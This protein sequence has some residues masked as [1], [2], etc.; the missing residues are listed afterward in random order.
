MGIDEENAE[1]SSGAF[2]CLPSGSHDTSLRGGW[3]GRS[4]RRK[5]VN[6]V[7]GTLAV[8]GAVTIAALSVPVVQYAREEIRLA[9]LDDSDYVGT[10]DY[11]NDHGKVTYV[12]EVFKSKIYRI[13][14]AGS[15]KRAGEGTWSIKKW[16]WGETKFQFETKPVGP[17]FSIYP[18]RDATVNI[19]DGRI[20]LIVGGPDTPGEDEFRK[21]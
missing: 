17:P 13:S 18:T 19:R 7:L 9:G 11:S 5:P 16:E 15:R 2:P 1:N 4:G 12:L 20:V 3:A 6:G 10:Y 14:E 21:R 8:L